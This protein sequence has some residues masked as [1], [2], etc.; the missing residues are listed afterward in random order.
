MQ[1]EQRRILSDIDGES[2]VLRANRAIGNQPNWSLL[3]ALV[4]DL[5]TDDITLHE[6]A[7]LSEHA[8]G[9]GS[10][11]TV[12]RTY[13]VHIGGFGVDQDAV[14]QFVVRME[15][16]SLFERVKLVETRRETLFDQPRMRFLVT[17]E[18]EVREAVP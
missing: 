6:C 15:S 2:A 1:I 4:A 12:D 3:L 14:T 5:R 7:L 9:S 11:D 13:R 18:A 10:E 17:C 16:V 8:T